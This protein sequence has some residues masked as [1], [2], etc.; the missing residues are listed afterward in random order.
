M[1]KEWFKNGVEKFEFDALAERPDGLSVMNSDGIFDK[2]CE[3]MSRRKTLESAINWAVSLQYHAIEY[4]A[5]VS[6]LPT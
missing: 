2:G 5:A 4:L 6:C 1:A 3:E